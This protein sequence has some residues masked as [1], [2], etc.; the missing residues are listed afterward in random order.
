MPPAFL[1]ALGLV[2]APFARASGALIPA[3]AV[4]QAAVLSAQQYVAAQDVF[5]RLVAC[6]LNLLIV[7]LP[8]EGARRLVE[9]RTRRWRV[10]AFGGAG[11]VP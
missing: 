1:P 5:V 7:P 4:L 3:Y 2:Q 11:A 9:I 8:R 6:L 10:V